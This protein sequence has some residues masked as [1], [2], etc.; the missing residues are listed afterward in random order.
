MEE[1]KKTVNTVLGPVPVEDL[2]QTLMHEHITCA[3]WSMRMAFGE[4]YFQFD[5]LAEMASAQL[6]RAKS[7]GIRTLVDGTA[8]NLGR[9][10]HLLRAAA[11]KSGVNI[12]C[13]SGFY[14]QEEAWLMGRPEKEIRALLLDEC[15]NG[16]SGTDSL[17]GIMKNG[18]TASGVTPLQKKLLHAVGMV[19][20]ETGLPIFCHHDPKVQSGFD[21]LE[22]YASAGVEPHNVILG[23][24]GDSND[25]AY[26][27]G[28]IKAGCYI[29]FDRLAYGDRDNPVENCVRNIVSLVER[30]YK[31]RIFL[32]HDWASYL[33]FWESW[34]AVC[35]RNY[36]NLD[37]DYSYISRVVI[38][39]LTAAGLTAQDISDIM[40]GNPKRF[41]AEAG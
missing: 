28:L 20:H 11:E 22:V 39:M 3:D 24:T 12:I 8:V 2:G 34:D 6:K 13:S 30:G 9:D 14:Y 35:Q 38:P 36:E 32:S 31:D 23:H 25:W 16:I 37:I 4:K 29:G 5:R 40:I 21:V 1:N 7:F 33:G 19:A 10:I 41:F 18:I 17:P 15:T 26:H 27:E